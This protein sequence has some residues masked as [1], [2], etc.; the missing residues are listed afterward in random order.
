[1]KPGIVTG[2]RS[3]DAT[4]TL[5]HLS[6]SA[7]CKHLLCYTCAEEEKQENLSLDTTSRPDAR[8]KCCHPVS[9]EYFQVYSRDQD[10]GHSR[11]AGHGLS[12]TGQA[13]TMPSPAN[14]PWE[15][16]T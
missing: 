5:G 6:F 9:V 3:T 16:E 15:F 10:Y 13:H 12:A 1:M 4:I 14:P 11:K 2:L 7:L 8:F